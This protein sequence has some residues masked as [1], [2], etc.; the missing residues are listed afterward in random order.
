[1][2]KYK[3]M[4]AEEAMD[5]LI[6]AATT[7]MKE[8]KP[9]N[10]AS[11]QSLTPEY[12]AD[13]M[14]RKGYDLTPSLWP[15]ILSKMA[16]D[17]IRKGWVLNGGTGVGKTMRAHLAVWATN[18]GRKDSPSIWLSVDRASD[19]AQKIVLAH[20]GSLQDLFTAYRVS[21]PTVT[22]GVR[23]PGMDMVIDDLGSE[24]DVIKAFGTSINPMRDLLELRLE[25][26]PQV[27]T[28]ITTNLTAKEIESRYGERVASRLEEACAWVHL[29]GPDRRS[30]R[31]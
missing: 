3:R 14:T 11:T 28:Y 18:L 1:M 31:K 2:Q 27:K 13:A 9:G 7:A 25:L 16:N 6:S 10:A 17:T 21:G 5:R 23:F 26:F 30:T 29:D 22:K 24:A 19:L 8:T 20:E 4:T 15:T 12:F